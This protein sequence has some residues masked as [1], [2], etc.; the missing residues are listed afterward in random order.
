VSSGAALR[1]GRMGNSY[2]RPITI[3]AGDDHSDELAAPVVRQGTQE[4]RDHVGPS[5]GLRYGLQAKFSIENVQVTLLRNDE[6]TVGP[7]EQSFRDQFNLHLR[8]AR[9]NLVE[10]SGYCSQVID[11]DDGN[12]HVGRQIAQ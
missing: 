5:P 12:T 10:P 7:D 3:V 11:D 2:D 9:K 4:D 1:P 6:H 8:A